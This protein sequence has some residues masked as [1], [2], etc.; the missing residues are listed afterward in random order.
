MISRRNSTLALAS[1]ALA[2]TFSV[3]NVQAQD[4]PKVKL[5]TSMG[6]IVV[7]LDPA[8]APKTVENFLAYVND[9][10]YDG[11]VF[12]R[13]MNGFMIQGGGFTADMQ[14]KPT[15]PPI[16]LEA[17]NGLKNDT[18]T[19]AMARTGNPNSA[20]SQFFINV[21]DNAM[22][23]APS[24]DGH[25]YAVFGKVVSGTDVVDKIKAVAVGNKGPHQNVP[26]T[27]VTINSATLVK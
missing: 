26:N 25:G 14:Q 27:P 24:P 2:A 8:K 20:T 6:D 1:I 15:K 12:H 7:Q 4:G 21:T 23:N 17:N 9:K 16:A 13:V 18:Y 19:I 11:T 3:A 5:A 22:L 10:H